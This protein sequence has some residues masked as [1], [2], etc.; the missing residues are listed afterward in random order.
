MS[1]ATARAALVDLLDGAT[2][3]SPHNETLTVLEYP[4]PGEIGAED[5][6]L[7]YLSPTAR[8]VNWL[9]GARK[10]AMRS[11]IVVYLG[12]PASPDVQDLATRAE[13]WVEK[14]STLFDG[15]Q[16]LHGAAAV[17]QQLDFS[18]LAI[19]VTP[20]DE[21]PLAWGFSVEVSLLVSESKVLAH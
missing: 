5:L 6:P 8:T 2:I 14:F 7:A 21:R 9:P 20:L 19:H 11:R 15:A 4:P 12:P 3:T 16:A 10:T 17:V 13:A 18:D 1:W